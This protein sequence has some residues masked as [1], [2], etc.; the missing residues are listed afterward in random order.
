MSHDSHLSNKPEN[1][2]KSAAALFSENS[3]LSFS[4]VDGDHYKVLVIPF[5]PNHIT[6]LSN[7]NY[8][9]LILLRHLSAWRLPKN[10]HTVVMN[11]T[12]TTT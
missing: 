1:R 8:I 11:S 3:L 4:V 12:V 9:D 5:L 6:N 10:N 7:S 2:K